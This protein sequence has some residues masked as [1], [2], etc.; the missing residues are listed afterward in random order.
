MQIFLFSLYYFKLLF[1]VQF[2]LHKTVN[3]LSIKWRWKHWKHL[4]IDGRDAKFFK[5]FQ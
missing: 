5:S 1:K 4:H 2:G 3:P